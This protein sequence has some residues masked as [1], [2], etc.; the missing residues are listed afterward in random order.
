MIMS[1]INKDKVL[2]QQCSLQPGDLFTDGMKELWTVR[3]RRSKMRT[4][5]DHTH[6]INLF[7][8]GLHRSR[9]GHRVKFWLC[10]GQF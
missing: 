7:D 8:D 1:Y 5:A 9:G 6:R 2:G 4:E 10:Y 3:V